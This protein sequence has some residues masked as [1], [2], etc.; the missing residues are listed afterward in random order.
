MSHD[1]EETIRALIRRIKALEAAER[2]EIAGAT[3]LA[4]VA[5]LPA[6]GQEGR[7]LFATDGRKQGEGP[8][9]GTGVPVYDDATAWRRYSDDTTV[10]A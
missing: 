5:T 6:A 10:L 7:I 8:G 4:T 9:A 3:A 2:A 1:L